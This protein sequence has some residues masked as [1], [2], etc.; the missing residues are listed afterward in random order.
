MKRILCILLT[1]VLLLSFASCTQQKPVQ[2]SPATT[3]TPPP[4]TD[5][6]ETEPPIPDRATIP[7]NAVSEWREIGINWKDTTEAIALK[8]P[9]AWEF[10]EYEPETYQLLYD[11]LAVGTLSTVTPTDSFTRILTEFHDTADILVDYEVR[12][13]KE[14]NEYVYKHS[15][16]FVITADGRKLHAYIE[17]DYDQLDADAVSH[18]LSSI[19]HVGYR[20]GN[21]KIPLAQSNRSDKI[22]IIGNSFV[23]T[24][25]VGTF[26]Q[27]FIKTGDKETEVVWKSVN[28]AVAR[29]YVTNEILDPI[30]KGE[31]SV[32]FLCGLYY[33]EDIPVIG[34]FLK[35]CEQSDTLLVVFPAHNERQPQITKAK[36]VYPTVFFLDWKR[37]INDIIAVKN[38][39]WEFCQNDAWH[40]SKPPAG[41]IGAHMI[42]MALFDEVP[43]EYTAFDYPM[44]L[45]RVNVPKSYIESG[46]TAAERQITVFQLCQTE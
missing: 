4:E 3:D 9:T 21:L 26:L 27:N 42:Y 39:F 11:G 43:N 20:E 31:Y 5:P 32:V 33:D 18:M 14:R 23:R 6:P 13:Y 37:E 17:I 15:F 46:F 22:F 28:G 40:H 19:Q 1:A 38:N 7:C 24:S 16:A 45:V 2:T 44:S 12:L 41:Y 8:V 10:W 25:S 36:E 34:T 35:A 30:R 29:G